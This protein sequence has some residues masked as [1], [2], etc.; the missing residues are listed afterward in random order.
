MGDH[1]SREFTRMTACLRLERICYGS[2]LVL[3]I[4]A[5]FFI[6]ERNTTS[7]APLRLKISD[8]ITVASIPNCVIKSKEIM[9]QSMQV[10]W[11]DCEIL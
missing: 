5:S 3:G 8:K 11:P 4:N 1:G 6:L 2:N 9:R 10:Q 7:S